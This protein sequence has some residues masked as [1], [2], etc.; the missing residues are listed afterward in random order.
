MAVQA[1]KI[2]IYATDCRD[3]ST[4]SHG[5]KMLEG[6]AIQKSTGN[7]IFA[8]ASSNMRY[9]RRD[10]GLDSKLWEGHPAPM[11]IGS[12]ERACPEGYELEWIGYIPRWKLQEHG[13][14]A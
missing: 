12:Y 8:K 14:I 7:L 3:N 4:N 2:L 10:R 9:R 6:I 13:I 1:D 5:R 11:C